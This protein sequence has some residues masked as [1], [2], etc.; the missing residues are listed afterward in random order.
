MQCEFVGGIALYKSYYYYYYYFIS[1][2]IIINSGMRIVNYTTS[3]NLSVRVGQTSW[4]LCR[5]SRH[6]FCPPVSLSLWLIIDCNIR[7]DS[8]LTDL[9]SCGFAKSE[10][11]LPKAKNY[12]KPKKWWENRSHFVQIHRLEGQNYVGWCDAFED[13]TLPF[14]FFFF[15][16]FFLIVFC[17]PPYY[18]I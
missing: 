10:T 12:P 6:E 14:F 13:E 11:F 16:S 15:Y 9:R 7:D 8:I 3:S 4:P 1:I 2:I 5:S 17:L 18:C